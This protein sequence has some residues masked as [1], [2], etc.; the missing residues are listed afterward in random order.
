MNH[1]SFHNDPH[2]DPCPAKTRTVTLTDPRQARPGDTFTGSVMRGDGTVKVTVTE[3]EVKSMRGRPYAITDLP[4]LD[5]GPL[6]SPAWFDVTITRQE[7][8]KTRIQAVQDL[9]PGTIFKLTKDGPSIW[10]RLNG[11]QARIIE[12][13]AG[14]H[15]DPRN[16]DR[17]SFGAYAA[18]DDFPHIIF[19]PT[20]ELK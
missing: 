4:Y 16:I 1:D 5:H 13:Y 2:C 10:A 8:V 17:A 20:K 11:N 6:N 7:P 18:A 12:G 19:D 15:N 3:A 9:A 14:L